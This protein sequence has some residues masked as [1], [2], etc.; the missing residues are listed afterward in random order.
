MMELPET[1][2]YHLL[3]ILQCQSLLLLAVPFEIGIK[4]RNLEVFAVF[5]AGTLSTA[6]CLSMS[7][8][9]AGMVDPMLLSRP[10]GS[11]RRRCLV[12][13]RQPW[14]GNFRR[15]RDCFGCTQ[16]SRYLE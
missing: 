9:L 2:S 3:G 11:D 7:A 1:F 6:L 5:A 12:R 10:D 4:A 14:N 8:W 15:K 16:D 13:P